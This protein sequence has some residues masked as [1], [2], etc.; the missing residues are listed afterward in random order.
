[1]NA[2]LISPEIFVIGLGLMLMLADVFV[3]AE[4]RRW[5]GYAAIAALGFLLV[6]CLGDVS[7]LGIAFHGALS[8]TASRC[9]SRASL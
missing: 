4:R 9:F 2:S 3:P 8:M 7:R 1:M 5:I 6:N